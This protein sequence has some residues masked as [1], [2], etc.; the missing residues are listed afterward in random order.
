M[1]TA[2]GAMKLGPVHVRLATLEDTPAIACIYNQGIEDRVATFE[3]VLR[4]PADIELRLAERHPLVVGERSG[5]IVGWAGAGDYRPRDCYAGVAEFS[6]YTERS[7]RGTGVGAAV[8]SQLLVECE[9]RGYWKVLSRIFPENT[10]S[11]RLCRA[12]GFREVGIYRRHARL[13]GEWRDVVI[14]E[15]LLGDAARD[16]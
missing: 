15:K 3:T 1:S 6:V 4:T 11:L 12:L 2:P 16:G 13:D 7:A 5:S 10:A 8:L 9:R 14:V